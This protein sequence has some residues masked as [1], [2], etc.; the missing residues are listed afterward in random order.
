M[1][2]EAEA[3]ILWPLDKKNWLTE[4]TLMLWKIEGKKKRGWQSTRWLTSIAD[5]M[6]NN[7]S[8]LQEIVEGK[9]PGMLYLVVGES[10]MT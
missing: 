8:Q 7:L 9:E 3:S 6:D 1:D 4:K 10:N 5:S 2:A